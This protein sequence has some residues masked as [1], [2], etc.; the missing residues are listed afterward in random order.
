MIDKYLLLSK[1]IF[2]MRYLHSVKSLSVIESSLASLFA[3]SCLLSACKGLC[4]GH[5]FNSFK[6]LFLFVNNEGCAS[7]HVCKSAVAINP[8]IPSMK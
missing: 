4:S 7:H 8:S 1:L 6:R 3:P 5:C 2:S